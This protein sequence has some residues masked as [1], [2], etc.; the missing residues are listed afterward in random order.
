MRVLITGAN[1]FIG[2]ALTRRMF[3]R[4]DAVQVLLR[5]GANRSLI[6]DLP[7]VSAEGSTAAPVGTVPVFEG[8]IAR[9]GSFKSALSD[10]EAVIHLA[11]LR[12]SH[13]RSE[14]FAVNAE[15]TRALCEE[16]VRHAPGARLILCSSLTAMGPSRDFPDERAELRP[17]DWYGESKALAE[18]IA[19]SFADR[20]HISIARPSRVVGPGDRENLF[21][22]RLVERG[23]RLS[24][25]G[26]PRPM[27]TLDV[28]DLSA[29]LCLMADRD[30][31]SGEIFCLSRDTTTLEALNEEIARQMG[32]RALLLHLPERLLKVLASGADLATRVSGRRL[33]LNRKLAQQI[34]APGWT[35]SIVKAREKLG[36]DPKISLSESV[37]RSLD[38]YRAHGW[39]K[40]GDPALPR[41]GRP[42]PLS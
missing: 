22:F 9:R 1:G 36:F 42:A 31:A 39:L 30:G 23:L 26:T 10:V 20:L 25:G 24:I 37:T 5:P 8:E 27:S 3:Q 40:P 28:D 17:A 41:A 16:M 2:S 13:A 18:E 35:C 21:F 33:P 7:L 4:G 34:L 12:R 32:K 14:L 29:G 38:W 19:L 6:A 11:G 15:G